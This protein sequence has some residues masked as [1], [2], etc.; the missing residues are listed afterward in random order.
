MVLRTLVLFVSISSGYQPFLMLFN[1]F[2]HPWQ[3]TK[4]IFVLFLSNVLLVLMLVPILG[5]YGAALGTGLSF[6]VQ[7]FYQKWACNHVLKFKI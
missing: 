3:Q 5:Y 1:Q 6:I 4:F 7:L 2:G